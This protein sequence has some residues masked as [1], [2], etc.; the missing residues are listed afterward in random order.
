[1]D[2]TIAFARV[3]RDSSPAAAF[4]F[5]SGNGADPTGRSRLAYARDKGE[6]QLSIAVESLTNLGQASHLWVGLRYS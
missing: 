4:S 6:A 1:V 2:Y 5:L 3:F